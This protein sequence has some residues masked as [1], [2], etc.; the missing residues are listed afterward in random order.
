[1]VARKRH[2]KRIR[3]RQLLARE[4]RVEQIEVEAA[5]DRS[6]YVVEELMRLA[7]RSAGDFAHRHGV[8]MVYRGRM[9]DGKIGYTEQPVEH[10]GIRDENELPLIYSTITSP[11]RKIADVLNHMQL[12]RTLRALRAQGVDGPTGGPALALDALTMRRFIEDNYFDE[13]TKL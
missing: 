1:M 10:P 3:M 13:A 5:I 7:N 11:A 12:K 4:P 6:H 8:A 9:E 2:N